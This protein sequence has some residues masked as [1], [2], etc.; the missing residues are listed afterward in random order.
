[1]TVV[2]Y[3]LICIMEHLE[4]RN[5]IMKQSCDEMPEMFESAVLYYCRSIYCMT[6]NPAD[7]D[8]ISHVNAA[9]AMATILY[10]LS[11]CIS[12]N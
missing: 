2:T 3:Y 1:M 4:E 9:S 6:S 8:R 11:F 5:D 7:F 12:C 10:N